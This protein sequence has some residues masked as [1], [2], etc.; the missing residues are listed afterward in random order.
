VKLIQIQPEPV[1]DNIWGLKEGRIA[2]GEQ[3]PYPFAVKENGDVDGQDFWQGD[4]AV[5]VGFQ[6]D[7][8]IQRVDLWWHDAVKDP[9]SIVGK[10]PVMRTDK[11]RLYTYTVKIESVQVFEVSA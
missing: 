11:G 5:V 4:P 3:L 9:Q 8:E 6:N 7:E 1:I 10:F 2:F